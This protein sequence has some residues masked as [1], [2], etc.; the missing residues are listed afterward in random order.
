MA[1]SRGPSIVTDGLVLALDAANHKSYPGSGTTWYDL[2]GNGNNGTLT[3]GPVFSNNK[4]TTDG[5]DDH[6]IIPDSGPLAVTPTDSFTV[7]VVFAINSLVFRGDELDSS[8]SIFGRGSTSGAHGIGCYQDFDTGQLSVRMGSRGVSQIVE[9]TNID[10]DRIYHGTFTYTPTIQRAYLDS[11]E[12]GTGDTTGGAGG[13]F[14]QFDWAILEDRAVPGGNGEHVSGSVFLG[15]IY[16][17]ALSAS[18]I[19]QNYN[20]TKSRFGL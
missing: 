7:E 18:E 10:N 16:N 9:V 14:D 13:T 1:F 3:N 2:S 17:R 5:I 4:I 12:F 19:Q 11:V 20:A 15:R 8:C 6:I